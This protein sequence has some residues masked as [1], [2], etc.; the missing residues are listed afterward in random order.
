MLSVQRKLLH[1]SLLLYFGKYLYIHLHIGQ[2]IIYLQRLRSV[3]SVVRIYIISNHISLM[4]LSFVRLKMKINLFNY[5]KYS[6]FINHQHTFTK[7][8]KIALVLLTL[9][10]PI[11]RGMHKH[12]FLSFNHF[13]FMVEVQLI[14]IYFHSN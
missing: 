7:R 11:N 2:Y 3:T 8:Q 9:H 5:L 12:F 14:S 4:N 13:S 10:Q 6:L 1:L